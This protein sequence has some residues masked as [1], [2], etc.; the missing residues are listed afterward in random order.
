VLAFTCDSCG[1][2]VFFDNDECLRCG[3][4]LGYV[5]TSGS[6]VAL[7]Q[8][9]P[10]RLVELADP[11]EIWQRCA[12]SPVTGCNWLVPE[13]DPVPC[14]SCALTRTRPADDD[15]EG[16][17]ELVRAEGAKRRLIFQLDELEL[18]ITP[19]NELT[20][21]GLAFDLLS[22][23]SQKV[24]T[25]HDEGVITLDL[26]EADDEHRE[27]LRLHLNEPYRTLLGHFRHEIGHYYWPIL[28]DRTHEID[29]CRDL[30]GDERADYA[31]AIKRHYQSDAESTEWQSDFISRYATMHPFE[32]WAE[33]FA[34]YL[35]MLDTLQT[36][37]SF[38]LRG[39]GPSEEDE[40]RVTFDATRPDHS[41]SFEDLVEHWLEMTYALNQ[42]SRSMGR[43]DLYPFVLPPTV[44]KKMAFVDSVVRTSQSQASTVD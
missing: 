5:P 6:V 19:R 42:V 41:S 44:I 4:P 1:Q 43:D 26:A 12:T 13:G 38:G 15:V 10:N 28:V 32:D 21:S 3:S 35:H 14:R 36:A 20:E 9:G 25:G 18:P 33:T 22:S 17:R 39:P 29:E 37:E 40:P 11:D 7:A 16:I 31:E 24:I 30:F 2:K 27:Q 34:H 8:V 23:T